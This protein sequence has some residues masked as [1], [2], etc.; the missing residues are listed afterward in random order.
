MLCAVHNHSGYDNKR[1][2]NVRDWSTLI[3]YDYHH[4]SYDSG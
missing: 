3:T 2:R 1:C 4:Q